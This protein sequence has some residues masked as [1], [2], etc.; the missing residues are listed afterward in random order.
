MSPIAEDRRW[1]NADR[2]TT[3]VSQYEQFGFIV[4]N[5]EC[6][7]PSQISKQ[8]AEEFY[9]KIKLGSSGMTQDL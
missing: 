2:K 1:V 7:L 6:Q 8:E 9:M 4:L 3:I 5:I